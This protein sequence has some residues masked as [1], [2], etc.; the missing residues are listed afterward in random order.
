MVVELE[1]RERRRVRRENRWT[2][3]RDTKHIN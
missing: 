2:I 1:T 3:T